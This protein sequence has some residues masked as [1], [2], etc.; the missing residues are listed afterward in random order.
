MFART[1]AAAAALALALGAAPAFAAEVTVTFV[2]ND[3]S[4]RG[5]G[6]LREGPTGVLVNLQLV[7]LPPGWHGIHFHANGDCSDPAFMASGGHIHAEHHPHG[8]LNPDGP[9]FGDLPNVYAGED[10]AVHAELFSALVSLNGL[11]GRPGLLEDNGSAIVVHAMPDDHM[12]QPI[13]GA[14]DRIACAVVK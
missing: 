2:A 5:V 3:G 6:V 10:G 9:D 14:G 11:G 13:G 4:D 1:S 12:T 8:L 7:G